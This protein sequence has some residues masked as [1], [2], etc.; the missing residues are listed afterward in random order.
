MNLTRISISK[1]ELIGVSRH[2]LGGRSAEG[3][4]RTQQLTTSRSAVLRNIRDIVLRDSTRFFNVPQ[5]IG[6]NQGG[7]V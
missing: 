2:T 1:P 3:D 6:V 7:P 5:L 4:L